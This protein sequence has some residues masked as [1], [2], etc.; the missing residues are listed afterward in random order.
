[1]QDWY[2]PRCGNK[3]HYDP[4][5]GPAT[6]LQ[7]G[8]NPTVSHVP[9]DAV[10]DPSPGA[11]QALLAELLA[12]WD[13]TFEPDSLAPHS[14]TDRHARAWF[15]SYDDALGANVQLDAGR[16]PYVRGY[17][18]TDAEMADLGRA[19]FRLQRGDQEVAARLLRML[20]IRCPRFADVWLWLTATTDDPA[21]RQTWLERAVAL[22]PA[23][24]LAVDALA[25]YQGR[26]SPM[27]Q[28]AAPDAEARAVLADCPGCGAPLHHEPGAAEVVCEHCGHACSLDQVNRRDE[29]AP[30]LAHLE[31][32]RRYEGRPWHEVERILRCESC[33]A[34][35][36]LTR[37]QARTCT[38]CGSTSV[39]VADSGC[40]LE[41][42]QGLLPMRLSESEA[43]QA[44]QDELHGWVGRLARRLT[45]KA[46]R[47]DELHDVYLPYWV[48]DG[49]VQMRDWW[50]EEDG[51]SQPHVAYSRTWMLDGLLFPAT[52]QPPDWLLQQILPFGLS[53]IVP[54]EPHLLADRP[55]ALYSLDVAV[56]AERAR[57]AMIDQ[58]RRRLTVREAMA[59]RPAEGE[60]RDRRTYQVSGL[61][62]CRC[63]WRCCARK[64]AW[65]W[66]WSTGR[67]VRR[68]LG[69]WQA[70]AGCNPSCR[71]GGRSCLTKG[72]VCAILRA[73]R[74]QHCRQ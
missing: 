26:V 52:A 56:V 1:M 9:G 42:P 24:P 18:P 74:M 59:G 40:V 45:G 11:R 8:F 33:G 71:A 15:L 21:E 67:R 25:I 47:P 49:F 60:V 16:V 29:V 30:L 6:C 64:A 62:S 51:R 53:E 72:H 55:A 39:L 7:C 58:A 70:E 22:E 48:F 36:S 4:F 68:R 12:H 73:H 50:V 65:V 35:L 17:L 13:R 20:T 44:L 3:S 46:W 69:R 63:G 57:D 14:V 32:R 27:R 19:Y 54:Y 38:Y 66:R 23:H 10:A 61:R 5:A 41:S 43:R 37:Y 31:L 2:C 28:T 34:E